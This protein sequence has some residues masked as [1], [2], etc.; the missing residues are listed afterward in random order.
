MHYTTV[1]G[2]NPIP[3]HLG[4]INL[5]NNGINYQPQLVL[6][7]FLPS[8]VAPPKK[9]TIH[10]WHLKEKRKLWAYRWFFCFGHTDSFFLFYWKTARSLETAILRF[11]STGCGLR[12]V[13]GY[14]MTRGTF[15]T[16][17]KKVFKGTMFSYLCFFTPSKSRWWFQIFFI[18]NP[19]WGRFPIW[20]VFFKGVETTN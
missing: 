20:L 16:F 12:Y 19:T 4:Y 9:F 17:M 13:A 8:T 5:V 2:R 14:W 18:F 10:V 15:T 7:G 6:F 1:D 11:F 3:N